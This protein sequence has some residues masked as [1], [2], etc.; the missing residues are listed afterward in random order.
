MIIPIRCY[1]CGKLIGNRWEKYLQMLLRKAEEQ[2][3]QDQEHPEDKTKPKP[4]PEKEVLDE[5]GVVTVGAAIATIALSQNWRHIGQGS[6]EA[7]V[8]SAAF[9]E[10]AGATRKSSPADVRP[11]EQ[12]LTNEDWWESDFENH[13]EQNISFMLELVPAI[14]VS[15]I[16]TQLAALQKADGLHQ[17]SGSWNTKSV[18]PHWRPNYGGGIQASAAVLPREVMELHSAL[19]REGKETQ[20]DGTGLDV[21]LETAMQAPR[22][23]KAEK[24]WEQRAEVVFGPRAQAKY[25]NFSLPVG[26]KVGTV[27]SSKRQEGDSAENGVSSRAP[28]IY[29]RVSLYASRS[30]T[31]TWLELRQISPGLV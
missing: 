14:L 12:S 8:L 6:Q 7:S 22:D 24:E 20:P 19:L 4:A 3:K 15:C 16:S 21:N 17:M 13:I 10:V 27:I 28:T 9:S 29:E 25:L 31:R 5:L 11:E 1:S 26:I 23:S 2:E 30:F 18:C